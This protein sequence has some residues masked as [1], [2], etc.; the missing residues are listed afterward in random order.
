MT[1]RNT[2]EYIYNIIVIM[3]TQHNVV[4]IH[5]SIGKSSDIMKDL[6]DNGILSDTLARLSPVLVRQHPG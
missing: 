4:V 6:E 5:P 1:S 3:K 2:T